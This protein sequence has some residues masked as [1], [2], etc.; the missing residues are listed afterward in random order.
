MAI[1]E[2]VTER[3]VVPGGIPVPVEATRAPTSDAL[4]TSV[5]LALERI[6]FE[7]L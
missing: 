3:I 2:F 7:V 5:P 6:V 4:N 1:V